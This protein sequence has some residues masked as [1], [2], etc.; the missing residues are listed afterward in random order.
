[1]KFVMAP[2]RNPLFISKIMIIKLPFESNGEDIKVCRFPL[3]LP[4]IVLFVNGTN[5]YVLSFLQNS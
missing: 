3:A 1:M 5:Q 2:K 4:K